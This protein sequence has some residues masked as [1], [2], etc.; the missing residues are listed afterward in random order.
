MNSRCNLAYPYLSRSAI[1]EAIKLLTQKNGPL[2]TGNYNKRRGDKTNWYAFRN[3]DTANLIKKKLVYFK[4][5][6]ACLYSIPAAVILNNLAYHIIQKRKESPGYRFQALSASILAELL[7]FSR[8]TI[9]R[10]L[11]RLV[12]EGKL[13]FRDNADT[14][15]PTE[16]CFHHNEDLQVYLAGSNP[17]SPVLNE[18]PVNKGD[19][20]F[21][22]AQARI[23][24]MGGSNPNRVGSKANEPGSN[25]NDVTILINPFE[26]N[27][28]EETLLKETSPVFD[29]VLLFTNSLSHHRHRFNHNAIFSQN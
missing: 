13:L 22:P 9:Q 26:N 20:D 14:T 7:P 10:A 17:N 25:P 3:E 8:S 23:Q 28:L 27:R 5:E 1:Y 6:D 29:S 15:R 16:Y 21:K 4:V 24:Q 11:K 12:D 2:I 19:C 18:M